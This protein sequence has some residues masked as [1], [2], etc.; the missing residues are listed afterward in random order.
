[1]IGL[2]ETK[3][4]TLQFL[5]K[6]HL[7][8]SQK[9]LAE[10]FEVTEA[11]M[12]K[13]INNHEKKLKNVHLLGLCQLEDIPYEIFDN[14]KFNTEE[15][16][17]SF[18]EAYKNSQK[19][20]VFEKKNEELVEDLVGVWYAYVHP[21]NPLADIYCIETII[22]DDLSVKDQH[23]NFGKVFMGERQSIM[24]KKAQNSRNF[25]NIVFDND[26]VVYGMF[27]FSMLSKTNQVNREMCNFGFFSRK[28]LD[29]NVA[30]K[31]LGE[32]INSVQMKIDVDFKERVVAYGRLG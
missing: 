21:S 10:A 26:Q 15:K 27:P 25:V 12:S 32:S 9:K 6:K 19:E 5:I 3:E 20:E 11:E 31:I 28:K 4:E 22:S 24:V 8:L 7:K 16:V 18:L 23:R 29:L 30:Q 13:I 1:M 17:V 14:K 2:L